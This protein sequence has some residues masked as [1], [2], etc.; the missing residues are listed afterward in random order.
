MFRLLDFGASLCLSVL[1]AT[2]VCIGLLGL[3]DMM[4]V[5]VADSGGL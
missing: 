4:V 2:V 5:L 3:W 1:P